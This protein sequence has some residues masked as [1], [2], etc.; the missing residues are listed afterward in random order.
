MSRTARIPRGW[1]RMCMA[2][3]K[4]EDEA[5]K[6]AHL[7]HARER[8]DEQEARE[9]IADAAKPIQPIPARPEPLDTVRSD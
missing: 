1:I 3:G 2:A 8:A 7:A 5:R 6:A 9:E 4:A